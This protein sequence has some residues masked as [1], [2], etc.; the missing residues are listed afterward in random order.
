MKKSRMPRIGFASLFFPVMA[1]E[2]YRVF[3]TGKAMLREAALQEGFEL[4]EWPRMISERSE[5]EKAALFLDEQGIDLLLV[6]ISSLIMG[7]VALPLVEK[8][9][10]IAVWVLDEPTFSGELP[11]NSLTGY[12]LFVSLVKG[13]WADRKKLAWLWGS[14]PEFLARLGRMARALAVLVAM[15]G[16]KILSIGG[17]V[18]SFDNL[19]CDRPRFGES[20]GA[21][22][23]SVALEDFFGWAESAPAPEIERIAASLAEKAS[24]VRVGH[25]MMATTARICHALSRAKESRGADAAAL[26]CWP[27]FQ[28]WKDIAPCAAVAWA[29]DH[30]MP[31]SCEGDGPGAAAMLLGSILSGRPTTMND[32]VALDRSTGTVQM[33]HCG[34]GPAS[35]ADSGG[36]CLDFHH[37]LNRRRPEGA[38]LA[39]VS[40]DISFAKGPVTMVRIRADGRSLFVM[41]GNIVDGPSSPYPG[42]GGWIGNLAM[43]GE[44]VSLE[45]FLQMMAAYGLEHHYPLMRGHH[46]ATLRD[47]ADW[48][49]WSILPR[50]DAGTRIVV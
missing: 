45:D 17:T 18:P 12:N 37:T 8:A 40:S 10:R 23:E 33:W 3:E 13:F 39:G 29:N 11:L 43:G 9:E 49:G 22:V 19:E 5:A 32:P 47:I 1:A 14:G 2:E 25:E 28:A 24:K 42:S 20:L 26:R 34:P 48:A 50:I 15:R 38:R 21:S 41:E 46:Y 4:I 6:Q 7:D 31:V 35:W 44:K 30:C 36:Q 16:A 27:E